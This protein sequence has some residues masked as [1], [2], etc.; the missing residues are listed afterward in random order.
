MI[1]FWCKLVNSYGLKMSSK[2]YHV[3]RNLHSPC[4]KYV[5][6]ILD[7]CGLSYLWNYHDVMHVE[8]LKQTV[9][10]TLTDKFKQKW[11]S[12]MFDSSKGINYRISKK[13]LILEK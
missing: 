5:H 3:L 10:L 7:E 4:I 1:S 11:N 6:N 2:L 9:L 12:D 8:C 13:E